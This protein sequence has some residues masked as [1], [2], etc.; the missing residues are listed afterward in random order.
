MI[1][2]SHS[3]S[4]LALDTS[5]RGRGRNRWALNNAR[6]D[7]LSSHPWEAAARSPGRL[8]GSEP[9]GAGLFSLSVCPTNRRAGCE[10]K[11]S[12]R[13]GREDNKFQ[14][15]ASWDHH[16]LG[17]AG[18]H[19]V[20][21]RPR[22]FFVLRQDGHSDQGAELRQVRARSESRNG[23]KMAHLGGSPLCDFFP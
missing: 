14:S 3:S 6:M 23:G 11:P 1:P 21:H 17:M 7:S 13:T 22:G 16:G 5:R 15:K 9:P 18:G 12:W 4:V 19:H 10:F 8:P 20:G 2:G